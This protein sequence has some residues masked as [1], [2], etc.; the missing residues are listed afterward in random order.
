MAEEVSQDQVGDSMV[1]L[2]LGQSAPPVTQP[3]EEQVTATE[4]AKGEVEVTPQEEEKDAETIEIDPDLEL[5]EQEL[6]ENGQK[7]AK[8]LSLREL[9][10][11]YLRQADYTRKTQDLAKQRTEVQE[12][13]RQANQDAAKSYAGKLDQLQ[14]AVVKSVA[15]ELANVDWNKLA[16]EDAFE[17]VRLSNRARQVNEVLQ[18]IESEK[19]S[20]AEQSTKEE[21]QRKAETW[22]KTVAQLQQDIPEWGA[23][24]AQKLAKA[25]KDAGATD[26]EVNGLDKAWVIKLA[27]KAALYDEAQTKT[28]EV[29]KKVLTVPRVLK[30]GPKSTPNNAEAERLAK[31]KKSGAKV[32]RDH[33]DIFD[34]YV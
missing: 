19:K 32:S 16:T 14:S 31:W 22:A 8:K 33:A 21:Q 12:S 11:G 3:E 25:A 2:I 29:E 1:D 20:I 23:P 34:K 13:V 4:E 6:E 7:V 24:V 15:P 27:H 26:D 28:T 5:F 18:A 9:Q 17:Y 10:K 30:P